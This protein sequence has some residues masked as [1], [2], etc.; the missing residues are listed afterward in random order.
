MC[1]HVSPRVDVQPDRAVDDPI[2]HHRIVAAASDHDRA[3]GAPEH[4]ASMVSPQS[5]SSKYMPIV[6]TC[7]VVASAQIVDVVVAKHIPWLVQS[8]PV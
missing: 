2:V 6:F 7:F 3:P 1:F 4:V 8:R 5:Q